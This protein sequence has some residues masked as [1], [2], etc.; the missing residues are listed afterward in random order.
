MA[1]KKLFGKRKKELIEDLTAPTPFEIGAPPVTD[2]GGVQDSFGGAIV[3]NDDIGHI[4]S[5]KEQ[6]KARKGK[7]AIAIGQK[8]GGKRKV[9][10]IAL[11]AIGA[12]AMFSAVALGQ[13]ASR[14]TTGAVKEQ[15]TTQIAEQRSNSFPTGQAEIWLESFVRIYGTWDSKTAGARQAALSPYLAPGI[16]GQAGWNG[17]GTQSVIYAAVSSTPK[18]VD[19]QRAIYDV[20]YQ[21]QDGTFRCAKIPVFAYK[22]GDSSQAPADQW[23]FAVTANPTPVP[24]ALKISV[25]QFEEN[26]FAATDS[27]AAQVLQESF[28]PGFFTAWVTSD[29]DTLRQ[30]MKPNTVTFGLGGAYTSKVTVNSVTL[31]LPAGSSKVEP[32]TEYTA[33]VNVTFQ[34]VSGGGVTVTYKVPVLSNGTQWQ[35][36]GEPS[37]VVQ[38]LTV[39]GSTSTTGDTA[40]QD[41]EPQKF[42]EPTP[43]AGSD[44]QENF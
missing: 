14:P 28:F 13:V 7:S 35:V 11:A 39:G 34:S 4:P 22:P 23:G 3:I 6:K 18:M 8:Y 26:K 33:Y 27:A 9:T 40:A 1:R 10:V 24:C 19:Q 44:S 2:A 37:E 15:I 5:E 12:S 25:P 36:A 17:E 38:E 16:D 41:S 20:T 30:Y 29:E 32:N 43:A 31:P 42:S 21:I